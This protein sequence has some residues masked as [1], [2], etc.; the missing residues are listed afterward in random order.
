M[1]GQVLEGVDQT[2]AH[3]I[4]ACEQ[5]REEDHS[6]FTVTEFFA[7]LPFWILDGLEPT[8]KHA[9][10]F[11]AVCHVNFAVGGTFDEPL[12][13]DLTS[14]DGPV[15]FGSG[16]GK[17]EVDELEGTGDIPVLV[18]DLL[19]GGSGD[20]ISTEDA[21]GCIHVEMAGD[22]HNGMGFSIGTDP[23]AEVLTGNLVL[24]I[25]VEAVGD[26]SQGYV[27][28]T[29]RRNEPKCFASEKGIERFAVCHVLL[30]GEEHP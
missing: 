5:E 26:V 28:G 24:D 19:G 4:L 20:V 9:G 11:T 8:V 25:K 2:T 30:A 16:E 15:D 23:I 3:S 21:Q 10:G 7:A 13:G 12:E 22:H 18:T 27:T 6:H 14:L 1:V 29:N 17:R